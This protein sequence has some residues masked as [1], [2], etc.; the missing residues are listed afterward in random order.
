V[1]SLKEHDMKHDAEMP[2]ICIL[3]KRDFVLKSSLIRHITTSHGIDPTPFVDSDK[4]LKAAV[5]PQNWNDQVDVSV[6]VQNE[7]K[8]SPEL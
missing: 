3:C 6:Y 8:E 4:C 5:I 7:I 2:F 1:N